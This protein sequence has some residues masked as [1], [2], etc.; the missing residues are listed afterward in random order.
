MA[1]APETTPTALPSYPLRPGTP[2]QDSNRLVI[3]YAAPSP[4][5]NWA[6]RP[7]QVSPDEM[8]PL[9]LF[10]SQGSKDSPISGLSRRRSSETQHA[11]T[12]Q[13]EDQVGGGHDLLTPAFLVLLPSG[14]RLIQI[15][16]LQ[17]AF[18][19]TSEALATLS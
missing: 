19:S 11:G 17:L 5:V 4:V 8:G 9:S 1:L 2:A 7:C 18:H 15:F 10:H 3:P 16:F 14:E 13:T 12:R 6:A